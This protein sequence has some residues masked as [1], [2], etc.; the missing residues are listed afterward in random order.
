MRD[1]VVR[2]QSSQRLARDNTLS[3]SAGSSYGDRGSRND[4]AQSLKAQE[5]PGIGYGSST[6]G[7]RLAVSGFQIC[8]GGGHGLGPVWSSKQLHRIF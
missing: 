5:L 3:Q 1:V 6:L 2:S 4:E 8:S 7:L